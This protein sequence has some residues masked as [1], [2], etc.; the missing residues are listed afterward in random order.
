MIPTLITSIGKKTAASG[1]PKIAEKAA[2]IPHIII[3]RLS[4]SLNFKN[5]SLPS[6]AA[7][8][9]PSCKAA[10][11]LPTEP[12]KRWVVI[13]ETKIRG[14]ITGGISSFACMVFIT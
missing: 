7:S 1:V 5:L 4:S 11:S 9:L 8:E 3:I 14:A 6:P 2:L 12:P 10:P 13:V